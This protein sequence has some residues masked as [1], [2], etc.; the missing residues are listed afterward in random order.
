MEAKH[1]GHKIRVSNISP[2]VEVE[3]LTILFKRPGCFLSF[4]AKDALVVHRLLRQYAGEALMY[5]KHTDQR[6][7]P[8]PHFDNIGMIAHKRLLYAGS[9][10]TMKEALN[11]PAHTALIAPKDVDIENDVPNRYRARSVK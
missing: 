6:L 8:R 5:P 11:I 3:F 4:H 7:L 10:G 9:S 1:R 2:S